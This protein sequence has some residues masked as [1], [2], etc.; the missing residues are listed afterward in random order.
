MKEKFLCQTC[1]LQEAEVLNSFTTCP[2]CEKPLALGARI[3]M[4][5]IHAKIKELEDEKNDLSDKYKANS[6]GEKNHEIE[7]AIFE[8]MKINKLR[9]DDLKALLQ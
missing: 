7:K 1:G 5:N 4:G 8:R 9:L 6:A 2:V 3:D